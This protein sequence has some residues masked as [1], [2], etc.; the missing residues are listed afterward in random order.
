[1]AVLEPCHVFSLI[2][3]TCTY[4]L[5]LPFAGLCGTLN[6]EMEDDLMKPDGS[7]VTTNKKRP[8]SFSVSWR[9]K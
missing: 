7:V 3:I 4:I 9:V 2:S 8:D 1:M 6:N 5:W